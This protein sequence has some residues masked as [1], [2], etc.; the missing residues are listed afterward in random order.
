MGFTDSFC[1]VDGKRKSEK[2]LVKVG[3]NKENDDQIFPSL[4]GVGMPPSNC[5]ICDDLFCEKI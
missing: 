5:E 1:L 4:A 2:Y 3:V